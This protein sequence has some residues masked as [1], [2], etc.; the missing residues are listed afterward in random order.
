MRWSAA[1]FVRLL[2]LANAGA[3]VQ[4]FI[5]SGQS[6]VRQHRLLDGG[7]AVPRFAG[8]HPGA[9]GVIGPTRLNYARIIPLV[10]YTAR[11]IG[12]WS[13]GFRPGRRYRR[14]PGVLMKRSAKQT[15]FRARPATLG[16]RSPS[17]RRTASRRRDRNRR[18][19][20][21]Q[22]LQIVELNL[23]E[24]EAVTGGALRHAVLSTT[25]CRAATPTTTSLAADDQHEPF[26]SLTATAPLIW[27]PAGFA[28]APCPAGA[29]PAIM[30]RPSHR[31]VWVDQRD[32]R[33][34]DA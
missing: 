3:G 33:R 18:P 4:I 19:V 26:S 11:T 15:K 8:T 22:Q 10:D 28:G 27:E 31:Q 1:S 16:E 17:H 9:I 5:G 13:V 14:R 30:R 6:A 21:V 25:R 29:A 34:T 23:N 7:G 32:R 20:S 24:T 2:E 12:G